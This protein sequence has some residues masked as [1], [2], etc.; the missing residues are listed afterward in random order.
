[1]I[2]ALSHF[3]SDD[4][5]HPRGWRSS[6]SSGFNRCVGFNNVQEQ[7]IPCINTV[8]QVVGVIKNYMPGNILKIFIE[9]VFVV[10]LVWTI[11]DS[12]GSNSGTTG[13]KDTVNKR[14]I[15]KS[16][17]KN[18]RLTT[19]WLAFVNTRS[20]ILMEKRLFQTKCAL[21]VKYV[22]TLGSIFEN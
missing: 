2:I 18:S 13:F 9:R 11:F 21:L 17:I 20:I 8:V 22:I 7:L 3:T 4:W 6:D 15:T 5:G 10:V 14:V 1:M 16:E 19:L 12:F